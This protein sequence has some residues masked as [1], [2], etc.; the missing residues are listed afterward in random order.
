[1][2]A[3]LFTELFDTWLFAEAT[4]TWTLSPTHGTR[5]TWVNTCEGEFAAA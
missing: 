3:A 1:V 2:G 4:L 5:E